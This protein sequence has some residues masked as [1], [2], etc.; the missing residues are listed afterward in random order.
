[1]PIL[2]TND[3]VDS[4]K[5]LNDTR[6]ECYIL[7]DNPY[8]FALPNSISSHLGF[9]NTLKSV[10]KAANLKKPH[11]LTTTRMRKHLATMAQVSKN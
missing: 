5:V 4:L 11:L 2:V 10:A 3:L 1:V 8:V 6:E 9:Y 7:K